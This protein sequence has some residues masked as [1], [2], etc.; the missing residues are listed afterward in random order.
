MLHK[1]LQ[2][3]HKKGFLKNNMVVS[4]NSFFSIG[5]RGGCDR[6]DRSGIRH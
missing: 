4:F 1:A 6:R 3:Q 2:I 5:G